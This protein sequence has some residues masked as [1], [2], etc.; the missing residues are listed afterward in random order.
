MRPLYDCF[1]E[2]KSKA[3]EMF[4]KLGYEIVINNGNYIKYFKDD[5]NV[6]YFLKDVKE[7]YKSGEYDGMCGNTTMQELQAINQKVKELEWLDEC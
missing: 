2:E 4:K 3:D 1:K 6:Y 7:F 5:E